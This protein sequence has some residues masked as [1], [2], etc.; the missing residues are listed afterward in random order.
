MAAKAF[1]YVG[2][3]IRQKKDCPVKNEAVTSI[4]MVLDSITA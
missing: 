1:A 2:G 3:K 4:E